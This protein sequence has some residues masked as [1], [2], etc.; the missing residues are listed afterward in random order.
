MTFLPWKSPPPPPTV[1]DHTTP[2]NP[3]AKIL[4]RALVLLHF[5]AFLPGWTLI[6]DDFLVKFYFKFTLTY[7]Q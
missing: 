4:N 7:L 2:I 6:A 1:G 5:V 3:K